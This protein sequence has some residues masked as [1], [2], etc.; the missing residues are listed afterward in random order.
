MRKIHVRLKIISDSLSSEELSTRTG[1]SF[2]EVWHVGER[3]GLTQIVEENNGGIIS[4]GLQENESLEFQIKELLKLVE[5]NVEKIKQLSTNTMDATVEL[6]CVIYSDD[7]SALHFDKNT[8]S[9]LSDLGAHL[10][11]DIYEI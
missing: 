1:L 2:D 11:I 3:R 8:I 5:S 9:A 4:S 6:S 10:D 7:I